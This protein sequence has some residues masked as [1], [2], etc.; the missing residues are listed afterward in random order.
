MAPRSALAQP[1]ISQLEIAAVGSVNI[2]HPGLGNVSFLFPAYFEPDPTDPS[3]K[4]L[5]GM[6]HRLVLDACRIDSTRRA[7]DFSLNAQTFGVNA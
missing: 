6:C 3:V 7:L 2:R 4:P 5:V 1:E